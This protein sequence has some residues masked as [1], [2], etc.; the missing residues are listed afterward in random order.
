MQ[1]LDSLILFVIFSS[2]LAFPQD[3]RKA[4]FFEGKT[5]LK[6]PFNLRDPFKKPSDK[7]KRKR[8]GYN[9]IGKDQYTNVSVPKNYSIK[10]IK[11]IG[12]LLGPKRRAIAK[13]GGDKAQK[14]L[15]EGEKIG[16][17]TTLK[18]ILPGGLVFVEKLVN[19]YGQE[20]Y[21]E[22]VVPISSNN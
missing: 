4:S 17:R 1:K 19:V 8:S 9:K 3:K 14:I 13:I 22:T 11:V 16:S 21:L 10:D 15:S 5:E 12:I 20:E 18:A 7:S 6:N 2:L